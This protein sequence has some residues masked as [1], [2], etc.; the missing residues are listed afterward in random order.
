MI[1]KDDTVT[2][3]QLPTTFSSSS[4]SS[5]FCV[6]GVVRTWSDGSFG[7]VVVVVVVVGGNVVKGIDGLINEMVENILARNRE[8]LKRV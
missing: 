6:F 2:K 8:Y 4:S 1:G 5:S 3:S 7:T